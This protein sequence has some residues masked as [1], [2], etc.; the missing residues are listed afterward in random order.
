[1]LLSSIHT[2]I[3][4]HI[5]IP[6]CISMYIHY[7]LFS[8]YYYFRFFSQDVKIHKIATFYVHMLSR[9]FSVFLHLIFLFLVY[10]PLIRASSIYTS[11]GADSQ[12]IG[13]KGRQCQ[14]ALWG[15][16]IFAFQPNPLRQTEK[17]ARR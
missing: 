17:C 12:E 9:S 13:Y 14:L 11:Q 4:I 15:E 16:K 2:H 5:H 6:M 3:H 7:L 8:Y 1:M 10:L